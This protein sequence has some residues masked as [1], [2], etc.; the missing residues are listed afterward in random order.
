MT[1]KELRTNKAYQVMC[2]NREFDVSIYKV[3]EERK[4]Q[5][6]VDVKGHIAFV[7]DYIQKTQCTIKHVVL[8]S[9]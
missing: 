5:W 9:V 2:K 8:I 3:C 7:N 1:E 4:D 6:A